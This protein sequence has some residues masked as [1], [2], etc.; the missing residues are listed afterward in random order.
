MA[1]PRPSYGRRACGG[2]KVCH[3]GDPLSAHGWTMK[4]APALLAAYPTVAEPNLA[5][6]VSYVDPEERRANNPT[7]SGGTKLLTLESRHLNNANWKP[8]QWT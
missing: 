6:R 7:R 2:S 8:Q 1:L 3:E 5:V 4:D